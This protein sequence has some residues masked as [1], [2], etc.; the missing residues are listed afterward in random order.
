MKCYTM[1]AVGSADYAILFSLTEFSDVV[2]RVCR[3]Y[4]QHGIAFRL[5]SELIDY[6]WEL[7]NGHP[8]RVRA[9]LDELAVSVAPQ[10]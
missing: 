1:L 4:S 2:A 5:S 7:T 3:S 10:F 9:V 6:I 8:A